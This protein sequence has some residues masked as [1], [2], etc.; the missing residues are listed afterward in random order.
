MKVS[1]EWFL[2]SL[3][4]LISVKN[5]IFQ[6]IPRLLSGFLILF[7][8]VLVAYLSKWL[9]QR[10]LSSLSFLI[11]QRFRV[12]TNFQDN[13]RSISYGASRIL[14]LLII[15]LT[16]ISSMEKMG[17]TVLSSWLQSIAKYI[18]N[19]VGA[20]F[21]LFLGWNFKN[22]FS[23][24]MAKAMERMGMTHAVVVSQFLSWSLFFL[25]A[26]VSVELIGIDLSLIAIILGIVIS[27]PFGALSLAF[28]LG[29]KGSFE[30]IFA[31]YHLRQIISINDTL[32]FEQKDMKVLSIGPVFVTLISQDKKSLSLSG[33]DFLKNYTIIKKS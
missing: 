32:E 28:A 4:I 11:P 18:P 31:C 1:H 25:F 6:F 9:C 29:I 21:I 10:I 22:I 33:R 24:M 7:L 12:T 30:D 26:L 5:E 17:L 3:D 20:T 14:F 8:G 13:I 19:L 2:N 15:L 27:I 23:H 16:I